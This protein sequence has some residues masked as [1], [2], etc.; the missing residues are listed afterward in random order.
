MDDERLHGRR[1]KSAIS[2]R[3]AKRAGQIVGILLIV[4]S[5]ATYLVNMVLVGPVLTTP[6]GFLV[7]AADSALKVRAGVLLGLSTGAMAVGI[8]VS[9][10]P[11]FRRHS[12]TMALWLL[13]LSI[14]G[15]SLVAQEHIAVLTMLSLSQEYARAGAATELF[16]PIAVVVRSARTWAHL[17]NLIVAGGAIFVLYATLWRF[18]LAPRALAAFGMAAALLHIAA[19]TMPLLG[20]RVMFL[21]MAPLGLTHLALS[22]R[23]ITRGFE[24][25]YDPSS[26]ETRGVELAEA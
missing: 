14:V 10:W 18:A 1:M 20:Y 11:V 8:A 25:R 16:Q 4:Q 13:A 24:E 7:S 19:V 23:L 17:T 9:A 12:R 26:S 5:F 21:L 22:F 15:F 3:S 6:P 2:A